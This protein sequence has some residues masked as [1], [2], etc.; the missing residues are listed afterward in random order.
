M[1]NEDYAKRILN[2]SHEIM[3]VENPEYRK[4]EWEEKIQSPK[5]EEGYYEKQRDAKDI[6]EE[7]E[8]GQ[9]FK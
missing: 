7:Q 9:R 2:M 3:N 4:V 1:N 8:Q 6:I 5:D